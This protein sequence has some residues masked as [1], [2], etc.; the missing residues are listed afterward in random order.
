MFRENEM[1]YEISCV[2]INPVGS[3][4]VAQYCAVGLW[5]D[6][7]VRVLRLPSLEQITKEILGGGQNIFSHL[8]NQRKRVRD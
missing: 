1:P 3:N 8:F 4:E 6:I 5:T 7:S 2:N